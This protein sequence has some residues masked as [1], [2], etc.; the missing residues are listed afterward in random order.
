ME[1]QVRCISK[2]GNFLN[3]KRKGYSLMEL[4]TT[5]AIISVVLIITLLM[6]NNMINTV[7]RTLAKIETI[8]ELLKLDDAIRNEVVKAGMDPE[9]VRL[10]DP[11]GDKYLG[12]I[13]EIDIPAG[14]PTSI[15][16]YLEYVKNEEHP[17]G[18]LVL[19][20]KTFEESDFPKDSPIDPDTL[21]WEKE[22]VLLEPD[23]E[24]TV[25]FNGIY[26]GILLYS[27]E[28]KYRNATLTLSSKIPLPNLR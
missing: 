14:S 13:F 9:K 21:S 2:G 15:T 10:V 7:N 12:M 5:V 23:I 4:L 19:R 6:F 18:I 3:K 25:L 20:E 16:K 27:I 24:A 22:T 17:K 26:S 1:V 11:I 8:Q 28:V